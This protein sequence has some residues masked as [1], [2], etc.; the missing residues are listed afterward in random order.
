MVLIYMR[1]VIIGG[2]GFIGRALVKYLSMRK[3]EVVVLDPIIIMDKVENVDYVCGEIADQNLLNNIIREGDYVIHLYCSSIPLNSN[4]MII[5]DINDNLV[6]TVQLLDICVKK[7]IEK[8]IFSSSGGSIYGKPLYIPIDESHT[9][10]PLS[11]YGVHKLTIE[12]YL[13]IYKEIFGLK[14]VSLRIANPYGPG[15]R[16][17][18]GQGVIST[19]L[20]S[21]LLGRKIQIWG[22]GSAVRDYV[23]INDLCEVFYRIMMYE[24]NELV[25]NVG[26]SVGTSIND[27]INL[28][29]ELV[30]RKMEKEYLNEYSVEVK[31]NILDCNKLYNN[32]Q[33]TCNTSLKKGLHDMIL[34]WDQE[35]KLFSNW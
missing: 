26:S 15:Q 9:T 34:T 28:V 35:K 1:V 5:K 10:N 27:I 12:K 13:N 14:T 19:F 29:E 2:N 7:K 21:A 8:F 30:G 22:D 25:F 24:G 23:Y 16:P 33:Y 11:I 20:A 17:F 4:T 32:L 6:N 31:N 18:T 3:I